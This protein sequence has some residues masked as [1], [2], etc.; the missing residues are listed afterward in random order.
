MPALDIEAPQ[1]S[2]PEAPYVEGPK[3]KKPTRPTQEIPDF[4]VDEARTTKRV[5]WNAK[6]HLAFEPP[7]NIV[8]MKEIG[9]EGHGI[10]KNAVSDP[11][12]LFT[13]DAMLQM[14]AELFDDWTLENCRFATDLTPNLIRGLKPEMAPFCFD[15]W[16]SPEVLRIVS[17]VAGVELVPAFDYE[18]ANVNIS[19]ND[20]N[21]PTVGSGDQT[22]SVGW[23][24]DSYPFVC[25]TMASD[26][27]GMVGGETAIQLPGG[28]IKKVRGPA[29][30]TAVVMQGRYIRHQALKAFGGRERIA[31][32][33]AFR[34][35]SPFVR[36]ESILTGVRPI[37]Y[38]SDLYTQYTEYRLENLE[39]RIRGKLREERRREVEKRP[40]NIAKTRQFLQEQIN[41]LQSMM[42]QIIELES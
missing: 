18:I 12:P 35:K 16:L 20:Q 30:G 3:V 22:S 38:T 25:V 15:A 24:Y 5:R 33:T 29:M 34:P 31:M 37:S 40:Y 9:L 8:T 39:E 19:I 36:D 6:E 1:V 17:E 21:I 14:R 27:T 23:H 2:P 28:E 32:V 7:K 42:G 11:F 26:C 10:S 4:I 41:Y 13:K